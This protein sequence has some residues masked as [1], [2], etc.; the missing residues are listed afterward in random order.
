MVNDLTLQN[1]TSYSG[2]KLIFSFISS[3]IGF[4]C[5]PPLLLNED[6]YSHTLLCKNISEELIGADS[7]G[8]NEYEKGNSEY[9]EEND[10]FCQG[11]AIP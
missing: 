4:E 2:G 6:L 10:I 9:S 8:E 1:I 7:K 11:G 5:F 3:D